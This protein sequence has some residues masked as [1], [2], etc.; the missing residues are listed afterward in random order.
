MRKAIAKA[1]APPKKKGPGPAQPPPKVTHGWVFV[2]EQFVGWQE[3]VLRALAPNFDPVTKKFSAEAVPAALEAV[4]V[5]AAAG[6]GS[7]GPN[8]KQLKSMAMPFVKYKQEEALR[9]GAQVLDVK[10]PFD[11]RQLLLD[12]KSYLLRALGL[13]ELSV[14]SAGEPAAAAAAAAVKADVSG[15]CPGQPVMAFTAGDPTQPAAAAA[16]VDGA[17]QALMSAAL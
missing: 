13:Q 2:A 8:E 10:L 15:A 1:E 12:N 4:K 9:G 14:F 16:G 6:S 11:E 7:G 3:A 5:A 17:A